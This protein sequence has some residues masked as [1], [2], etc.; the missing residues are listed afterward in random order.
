VP[1]EP[2][3][4]AVVL[5]LVPQPRQVPP[6]PFRREDLQRLFVDITREHNYQ[7]F[8]FL[9]A[10]AGAQLEN[11]PDER[12]VVQ[13]GLIQIQDRIDLTPEQAREKCAW[14]ARKIAERLDIEAFLQCGIKV[15]CHVA[16]P[17]ANADAKTFVSERLMRGAEQAA[18]LG[19]G[20]FGG[21]VKFRRIDE[22]Q[23]REENLLIEPF[24]RDTKFVFIDYDVGR[25]ATGQPFGDLDD[26]ATWVDEAFAFV[27]GP[28]MTL[29]EG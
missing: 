13:P 25:A 14:I 28:T 16:A 5:G 4:K 10:D 11:S 19:T 22:A 29:L 23:G 3:F 20:F 1:F 15:V 21:G 24:I 17:G 27:R 7:H 26:V 12:I 6:A 18:E 8:A 2:L 9:P